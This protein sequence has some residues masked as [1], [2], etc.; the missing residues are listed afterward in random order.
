MFKGSVLPNAAAQPT[1]TTTV[2]PRLFSQ[3]WVDEYHDGKLGC[4]MGRG[5]YS[6]RGAGFGSNMNSEKL[7][8]LVVVMA[9][10]T[11]VIPLH[12]DT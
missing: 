11:I 8:E 9:N 10:G 3:Q 7:W 12:S 4:V 1:E 2:K 6:W 5:W